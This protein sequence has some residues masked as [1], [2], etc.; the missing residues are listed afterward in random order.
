MSF[1]SYAP[2]DTSSPFRL[3]PFDVFHLAALAFLAGLGVLT[4]AFRR[5]LRED[6]ALER[7]VLRTATI[8][9]VGLEIA[10]HVCEFF[11]LP[12]HAFLRSLIPL[13]LCAI[14]LWMAVT[15]TFARRPGLFEILYFWSIGALASLVFANLD[16]AGP[17]RFRYYQYFGTHGYTILVVAYF[18]IVHGFRIRFRS[19]VKAVGILFPITL[20]LRFLNLAFEGPPWSLNYMY[21]LRPP[22]VETPLEAFGEGWGY[23]AAFVILAVALMALAWAPWGIA[24]AIRARK[25]SLP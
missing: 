2:V 4:A 1:F 23:Y 5:R 22:E 10:L 12:F 14:T 24:R 7:R 3:E 25:R 17:D 18:A 6:P 9:A 20:A 19:L 21:L 16:G 8:V 11:S 15:L 13:E